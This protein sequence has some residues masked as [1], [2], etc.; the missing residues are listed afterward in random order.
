MPPRLLPKPMLAKLAKMTRMIIRRKKRTT[1]W[2][3]RSSRGRLGKLRQ[4]WKLHKARNSEVVRR[5][6]AA[7]RRNYRSRPAYRRCWRR[8]ARWE[9][10]SARDGALVRWASTIRAQNSQRQ[11][12]VPGFDRLVEPF[13][14][15]AFAGQRAVPFA[16]II[17]D[18]ANLPLRQF[19]VDQRE[20]SVGPGLRADQ[21]VRS[22]RSFRPARSTDSAGMSRRRART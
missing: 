6:F 11:I 7:S 15:F 1:T 16:L 14:K 12:R 21:C 19:E 8:A 18:A 9:R 4:G 3:D 20:C 10:W 2:V 17:G 5:S 13:G 22:A